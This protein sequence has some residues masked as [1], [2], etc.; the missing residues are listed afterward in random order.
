MGRNCKGS[1]PANKSFAF[2]LESDV[3][4]AML[5]KKISS[6]GLSTSEFLR[7]LCVN[8]KTEIV[9]VSPHK[10]RAV[11]LLSKASNNLNQLAHQANS[12]HRA[13]KLDQPTIFLIAAELQKLN[14]F[15]LAQVRE[16]SK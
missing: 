12:A 2:R 6:S 16:E 13:G 15:L 10:A 9:P 5:E 8:E 1:S 11:F 3:Q 4:T 14:D 7:Q